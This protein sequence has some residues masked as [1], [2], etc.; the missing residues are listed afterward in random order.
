MMR[1]KT[2]SV[3]AKEMS[4]SLFLNEAW[5]TQKDMGGIEKEPYSWF[6]DMR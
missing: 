3:A 2:M 5:R 6:Y 1:S 4:V